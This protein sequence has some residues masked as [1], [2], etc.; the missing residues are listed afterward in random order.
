MSTGK[1]IK[2]VKNQPVFH[3][4]LKKHRGVWLTDDAWNKVREKAVEKGLSCSEYLENLI[5]LHGD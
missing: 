4:G 3:E 2:R 5:K 1:G